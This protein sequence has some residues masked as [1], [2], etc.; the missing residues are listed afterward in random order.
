MIA[1][2]VVGILAL[3]SPLLFI[4]IPSGNEWMRAL[5]DA[6]HG[7]IFAIV[8]M[9]V[10]CAAVRQARVSAREHLARLAAVPEGS[11]DQRRARRADRVPAGLRGE[12][13]VV[14]RRA[15]GYGRRPGRACS[16]GAGDLAG[17]GRASCCR[18][19]ESLARRRA[20]PRG[21]RVRAVAANAGG[22]RLCASLRRLP[23]HRRLLECARPRFR[24]DRRRGGRH[25]RHAAHPGRGG[26]A[27]EPSRSV[28][29]R[30]ILPPCRSSS[31]WATGAPSASSP[32]T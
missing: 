21:T 20:R 6:S 10:A 13:A 32:S 23:G 30:S 31:R 25:C 3:L 22:D 18:R 4:R 17:E 7:P 2:L 26:A 5:L 14:L 27:N 28:T 11:G 16:L 29:T 9:L 12:A 8:A 1:F 19:P 24:D 15:D